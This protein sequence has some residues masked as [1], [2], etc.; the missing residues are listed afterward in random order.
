MS[1]R[2]KASWLLVVLVVG[3]FGLA[4]LPAWLHDPLAPY[5]SPEAE[6]GMHRNSSG[7][8][9][10][11]HLNSST[12]ADHTS[13]TVTVSYHNNSSF[14]SDGT[15]TH[16]TSGVWCYTLSQAATNYDLAKI[17]WTS[18]G[19]ITLLQTYPT[20]NWD[21]NLATVPANVTHIDGSAL[22]THVAGAIPSD[23]RHV[24]GTAQTGGVVAANVTHIAGTAQTGADLAGYLSSHL[25][26]TVEAG[27]HL[28]S[29]AQAAAINSALSAAHGNGSWD[30]VGT[31]DSAATI[32]AEVWNTTAA[33]H[34]SSSTMGGV[35]NDVP[36]TTEIDT[37]LSSAHGNGSWDA[38]SAADIATQV[39]LTLSSSHGNGSWDAPS[40]ADIATQVESTL[41]A[42]H[43]N[44]SWDATDAGT[45]APTVGEISDEID[46]RH[47]TGPYTK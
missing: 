36:I 25:S 27:S 45:P 46:S 34:T 22:T 14:T 2:N 16:N 20:T 18:T 42:A 33:S 38:P 8:V 40:A 41:S 35:L 17:P 32:A 15:A 9:V 39:D 23:L 28:N 11:A 37:A 1:T 21:D 26:G 3:L 19:A 6:A 31:S 43:G 13:G 5:V 4:T 29:T 44:G 30:A 47:G 24:T 12:G 10:C 7:Q